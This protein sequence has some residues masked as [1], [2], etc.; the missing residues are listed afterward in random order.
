M[1]KGEGTTGRRREQEQPKGTHA[2]GVLLSGKLRGFGS[3]ER[4]KDKNGGGQEKAHGKE[5]LLCCIKEFSF[6]PHL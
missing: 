4:E 5:G 3:E 1:D 6:P 2:A